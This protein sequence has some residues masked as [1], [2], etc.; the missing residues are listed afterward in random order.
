[1]KTLQPWN[2]LNGTLLTLLNL[3]CRAIVSQLICTDNCI[4]CNFRN[5]FPDWSPSRHHFVTSHWTFH[6]YVQKCKTFAYSEST[7]GLL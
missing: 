2:L 5:F 7:Y 3:F 6:E 4:L 1:M